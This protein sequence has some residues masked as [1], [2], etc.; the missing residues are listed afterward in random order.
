MI[1]NP[2]F[3]YVLQ[4]AGNL[5]GM[6]IIVGGLAIAIGIAL[7]IEND[8]SRT[9]HK[10]KPWFIISVICFALVAVFPSEKTL[11]LMKAS[12]FVTYNNVNLTVD[13]LKSAID[14]A[15]TLF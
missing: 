9:S 13:A 6:L 11:L 5:R 7:F 14:Y 3:F 1:I 15:A 2:W 10:V 8:I 4:L 12:E